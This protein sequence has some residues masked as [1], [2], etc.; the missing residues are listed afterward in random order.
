MTNTETSAHAPTMLLTCHCLPGGSETLVSP[1][2]GI[3]NNK[4]PAAETP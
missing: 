3:N 2:R 1:G 4:L